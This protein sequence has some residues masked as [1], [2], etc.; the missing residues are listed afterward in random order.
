MCLITFI[1]D[2]H[3]E[4]PLILVA[5]RDE[6]YD[7]PSAAIHNWID[8]PSVTAGVDLQAFGTWLGYTDKGRFI[9]VLNHP[10]TAWE[11]SIQPPKSRGQLLKEYLT[12]DISIA[13]FKEYL[14]E[15]RSEYDGYHL[16]FGTFSEL[17]YY[18]NVNNT[19][20]T[21]ESGIHCLANTLDDLSHH[22][23]DR[24]AELLSQYV[25]NK[26]GELNVEELTALLAD[27]QLAETMEDYPKELAYEEAKMNSSIF[28]QGVEFGTVGTTA[29]LVR[30]DGH[31]EVREVRYNREGIIEITEKEQQLNK[32]K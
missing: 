27:K 3:P 6:L 25:E 14:T 9:T 8:H 2:K 10:F 13:D 23:R 12:S 5:N 31:V 28:I 15:H 16:L 17:N 32:N 1:K 21:F 22:R 11:T 4:Y 29:I 26:T 24:S 20:H 7:R 18:S 30:K 19:F